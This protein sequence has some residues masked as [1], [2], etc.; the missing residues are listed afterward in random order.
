MECDCSF[1]VIEKCKRKFPQVYVPEHWRD[2]RTA[3][4]LKLK[5]ESVKKELKKRYTEHK[6]Y[7]LG[8]GGGEERAPPKPYCELEKELLAAISVAAEGL[9]SE[10]DSDALYEVVL[11]PSSTKYLRAPLH[12]AL[13]SQAE[14]NENIA[15]VEAPAAGS[16]KEW[17]QR[18]RPVLKRKRKNISSASAK[19]EEL[20]EQKLKLVR[21]QVAAAEDA[22]Q[23]QEMPQTLDGVFRKFSSLL[24]IMF[25]TTKFLTKEKD[26]C[27]LCVSYQNAGDKATMKANFEKHLTEKEL[28]NKQTKKGVTSFFYVSKLN[29]F[30]FTVYDIKTNSV[31]CYVWN[32]VQ[33]HRGA[34][35]IGTCVLNYLNVLN[36]TFANENDV[37]FYSDNYCAGQQKNKFLLSMYAYAGRN[38][39]NIKS[40]THK[41]LITG[42]TQN[43]GRC[44]IMNSS[45]IWAET[46]QVNYFESGHTFMSA[47]SFHHKVEGSLT[48]QSKTLD[49]EDFK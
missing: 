15:A 17:A 9:T 39:Q 34:N 12:E 31:V 20:A 8:T 5:Y 49:F 24:E 30:N 41:Y 42:H 40:I 28:K 11:V 44:C 43:E 21:L 23:Q 48:H 29:V 3:K 37:L 33:G 18:R 2:T 19:F 35:E 10:T 25:C 36:N 22:R 6:A 14:N 1:G 46:I 45:A 47:D 4:Q 7:V 32:E 16:R 13:Q 26:Q 38:S 27:E